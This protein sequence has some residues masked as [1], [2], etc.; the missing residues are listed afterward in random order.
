[1]IIPKNYFFQNI[2]IKLNSNAW[3]T[4]KSSVV[5]FQ[6]LKPLQPQWPQWPQQP[7]WPQ[8]PPQPHFIKKSTDPDGLIILGTQMTITSP[9]LW[10]GSSKI[11]I[12]TKIG[13]ISVRGW[14]GQSM[15]L[16]WKLVVIPKNIQS[17]D[18]KTTF[19]QNIA[20]I[21]LSAGVNLKG[22]FQSE[23]PCMTE[24]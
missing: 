24:K 10:T 11:Q 9:F 4:L 14:W 23:T 16:L 20:C 7:Q 17:Q 22:T 6:A 3:M 19:K 21:F 8:W 15:L 5:I 18:S 13:N 12:S 2:K 1:M